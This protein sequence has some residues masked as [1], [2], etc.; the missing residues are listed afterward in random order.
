MAP[1]ALLPYPKFL[2]FTFHDAFA[3]S[4]RVWERIQEEAVAQFCQTLGVSRRR[5]KTRQRDPE[6]LRR[7]LAALEHRTKDEKL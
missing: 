5:E 3:G 2:L 4:L 1:H 7:I 6:Q